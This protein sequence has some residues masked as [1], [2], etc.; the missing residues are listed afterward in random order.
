MDY[1]M[2]GLIQLPAGQVRWTKPVDA[3]G[4]LGQRGLCRGDRMSMEAASTSR[5]PAAVGEAMRADGAG[6]AHAAAR[7][8]NLGILAYDE[9]FY[10]IFS[11]I[12]LP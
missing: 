3:V 11:E 5:P 2:R 12:R 7:D 6:D 1:R 4:P 10:E 9:E 8:A